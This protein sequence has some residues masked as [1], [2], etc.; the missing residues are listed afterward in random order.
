MLQLRICIYNLSIFRSLYVLAILNCFLYY[1]F[2]L[3]FFSSNHYF[4]IIDIYFIFSFSFLLL[5]C[6]LIFFSVCC[7]C[8]VLSILLFFV[9]YNGQFKENPDDK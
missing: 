2:W 4:Y 8:A 7:S 5:F 9:V 3:D 6:F 1:F